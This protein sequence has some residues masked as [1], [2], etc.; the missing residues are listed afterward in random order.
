MWILKN[1]RKPGHAPRWFANCH[2]PSRTRCAVHQHSVCDFQL[3][4]FHTVMATP[5][6]PKTCSVAN[7]VPPQLGCS[8]LGY[9]QCVYGLMAPHSPYGPC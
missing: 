5:L 6:P 1:G 4:S 9:T 3:R 7:G 2:P 8:F